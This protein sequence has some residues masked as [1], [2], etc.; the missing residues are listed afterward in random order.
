MSIPDH[1]S[2]RHLVTAPAHDDDVRTLI[3][4]AGLGDFPYRNIHQQERLA[5]N[6]ERWPLLSE[7]ANAGSE[8]D[9]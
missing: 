5:T 9:A 1:T 7:L 6:L 4:N 3:D 2:T 8:I